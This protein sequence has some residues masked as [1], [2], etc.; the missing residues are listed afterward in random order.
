MKK[1]HRRLVALAIFA[2]AG[3]VPVMLAGLIAFRIQGGSYSRELAERIGER[4]DMSVSIERTRK[5]T[6]SSWVMENVTVTPRGSSQPIATFRELLLTRNFEA[7]SAS[8]DVKWGE[9]WPGAEASRI[10]TADALGRLMRTTDVLRADCTAKEIK[11]HLPELSEPLEISESGENGLSL[12]T[13]S[14]GTLAVKLDKAQGYVGELR[15]SI[16]AEAKLP[17]TGDLAYHVTVSRDA[18]T[19][20]P[21]AI[22]GIL[23]EKIARCIKII[24]GHE[25]LSIDNASV[26]RTVST[27][28]L[29]LTLP[30]LYQELNLPDRYNAISTS[31][32]ELV[33]RDGS[34]ADMELVI[35]HDSDQYGESS[36]PASDRMLRTIVYLATG[37]EP[38]LPFGRDEFTFNDLELRI[39]LHDGKIVFAG[40]VAP[41]QGEWIAL[42]DED[43]N[44]VNLPPLAGEPVP[45]DAYVPIKDFASRWSEARQWNKESWPGKTPLIKPPEIPGLLPM[46][47]SLLDFW[48]ESIRPPE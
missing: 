12:E 18:G 48:T 9:I 8:L 23:G 32:K 39:S 16:E 38:V 45:P 13:D 21:K 43:A 17:T 40:G 4:L 2:G 28:N 31:L 7:K 44:T 3:A 42:S 26:V 35:R 41:R 11:L 1:K 6:P 24:E 36:S 22:T 14:S 15:I 20:L 47:E 30:P 5:P 29:E 46:W 25:V 27:D 19:L 34:I 10:K 33:L 37:K